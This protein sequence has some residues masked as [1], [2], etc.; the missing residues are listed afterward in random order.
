MKKIILFL[1]A[2]S[3]VYSKIN[4]KGEIGTN[5]KYTYTNLSNF[6]KNDVTAEQNVQNMYTG[7]VTINDKI[8]VNTEIGVISSFN[9]RLLGTSNNVGSLL[10]FDL[11]VKYKDNY[12]NKIFW[13]IGLGDNLKYSADYFGYHK[14][15]ENTFYG[16]FDLKYKPIEELNLENTI[17]TALKT[18][19]EITINSY[20]KERIVDFNYNFFVLKND[21]TISYELNKKILK[22]DGLKIIPSIKLTSETG[23]TSKDEIKTNLVLKPNIFA[24]Y[25]FYK[26]FNV[27]GEIGMPLTFS[28]MDTLARVKEFK[29]RSLTSELK[30]GLKYVWE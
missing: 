28:N 8:E 21:T 24:N 1:L 2:T 14:Q 7:Q 16:E 9:N 13:G 18:Y 19:T 26:G 11:S 29:M 5:L 30:V 10:D 15:Y 27:Y 22:L 20:S 4:I 12:E 6:S 23:F 25:N 3:F 17:T